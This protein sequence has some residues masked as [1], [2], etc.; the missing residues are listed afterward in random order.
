MLLKNFFV[1]ACAYSQAKLARRI[2]PFFS[3]EVVNNAGSDSSTA[4]T[5]GTSAEGV[6][7][8][9]AG[10]GYTIL[11]TVFRVTEH[12]YRAVH[13]SGGSGGIMRTLLASVL[14]LVSLAT[15]AVVPQTNTS[16]AAARTPDPSKVKFLLA[17]C[18]KRAWGFNRQVNGIVARDID[19]SADTTAKQ[20]LQMAVAFARET[21]PSA[22]TPFGHIGVNLRP[23]DPA[24]FTNVR[25]GF[26]YDSPPV[27]DVL[28]PDAVRA[29]TQDADQL[30]WGVYQNNPSRAR[31]QEEQQQVEQR[32]NRR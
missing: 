12:A 10:L 6:L 5:F 15:L 4:S 23:G 25:E 19:L 3:G 14:T 29:M 28:P 32:R 26:G 27:H 24:S 8:P 21:C 20:L 18:T 30:N 22:P 17:D 31:A 7:V 9:F 11:D 16:P 13:A 1:T 2:A